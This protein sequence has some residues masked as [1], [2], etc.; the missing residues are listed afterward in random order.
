[1]RTVFYEFA[2]GVRTT[3]YEVALT[4]GKSFATK[5]EPME[6]PRKPMSEKRKKVLAELF[7]K[8]R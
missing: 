4:S 2:D 5:V 8:K 7:R 3:S 6:E 1:M